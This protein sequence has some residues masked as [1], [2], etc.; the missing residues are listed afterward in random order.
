MYVV[1][2]E[3]VHDVAR[4][5]QQ[6]VDALLLPHHPDVADEILAAALQPRVGRQDLQAVETRPAAHDEHLFGRHAAAPDRDAA[7]G[8]PCPGPHLAA[9]KSPGSDPHHPAIGTISAGGV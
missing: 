3:V 2:A 5:L 1:A 6:I 4:C 7:A 8:L 9:A